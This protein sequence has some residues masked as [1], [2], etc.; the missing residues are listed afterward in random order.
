MQPRIWGENEKWP[1]VST[2]F[3]SKIPTSV[4]RY[5]PLIQLLSMLE[6]KS[7]AMMNPMAWPD[8]CEA[9]WIHQLFGA[10]S[11]IEGA[12]VRAVCF[13]TA[14]YCEAMWHVYAR[15]LPVV[16]VR[17][18]LSSL[19]DVCAHFNNFN[20]KFYFGEIRYTD[21][22]S[23]K[24]ALTQEQRSNRAGKSNSAA[25]LMLLKRRAFSYEEEVRLLFVTRED[26]PDV[27]HL[28]ADIGNIISQILVSPYADEW[29]MESIKTLISNT[30]GI[31]ATVERSSLDRAPSWMKPK[32]T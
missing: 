3:D 8:K 23:M 28:H 5:I 21:S 13:T 18:S 4:Y 17:F 22:S 9:G 32:T 6:S 10:G 20:G 31:N 1:N 25:T 24:D 27:I 19:A 7:I 29:M 14:A 12:K 11:A 16:R 26:T 15:M 2:S 30:Y